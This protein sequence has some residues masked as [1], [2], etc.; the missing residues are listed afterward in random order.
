[1]GSALAARRNFQDSR[2]NLV[3]AF[4]DIDRKNQWLTT[5]SAIIR[6]YIGLN[7]TLLDQATA[8]LQLRRFRFPADY[9]YGP[10]TPLPHLAAVKGMAQL[11]ALRSALLAQEN[12]NGDWT[13]DVES[14]LKLAGTLDDEPVVISFLVR[15]SIINIATKATERSISYCPLQTT[16]AAKLQLGFDSVAVSNLLSR[17]FIGELAIHTPIFRLSTSEARMANA[18][19][20]D[21]SNIQAPQR[22]AGK[23][24]LFLWFTGFFERD[25]NF[26]LETMNRSRVLAGQPMPHALAL[27]N[28]FDKRAVIARNRLYVYSGLLLPTFAKVVNRDATVQANLRLASTALAIERFRRTHGELPKKL[29]ELVPDYLA[30]VPNDPFDGA[31]LRYLPRETGYTI[32]SIGDDLKDDGGRERPAKIKTADKSSYDL[33]FIVTR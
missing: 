5:N 14:I 3:S 32:Y 4:T 25:L 31:A 10:D 9:S 11:F 8:A 6:D 12:Q 7:Q 27:R 23:P 16:A 28:Y 24:N 15:A 13:D 2:S 21:T 1:M 22:Y 17:A 20:D 18:D 30:T 19:S 33:T 26:F 29:E